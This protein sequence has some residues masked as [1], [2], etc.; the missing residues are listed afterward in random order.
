MH[1]LKCLTCENN[2]TSNIK[3]RKY[4]SDECYH[5]S[6]KKHILY[7][8][9]CIYCNFEFTTKDKEQILCSRKC[10][11]ED[12]KMKSHEM[13]ICLK[14]N[15]EFTVYKKSKHTTCSAECSLSYEENNKRRSDGRF[16]AIQNKFNVNNIMELPEYIQ[17]ISDTKLTRYGNSK[18]NNIEKGKQTLQEKYGVSNAYLLSRSNGTR[19]TKGQ[20]KL[21]DTLKDKYP[22]IL[23][24][25]Q[26]FELNISADIYI[27]SKNLVLEYYGDYWHCNPKFYTSEFYNKSL[28]KQASDIWNKDLDRETKIKA[29]GYNF[30]VIWEDEFNNNFSII[31]DI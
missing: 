19:I 31:N 11:Y 16:L 4:C 5:T 10:M 28:K 9:V 1:V 6:K 26:I 12:R 18:Y 23:L 2:F 24:E 21:Y 15:K 30:K 22:D 3:T 13:R 29:L 20:Q 14:C 8:K 17:K 7:H 27:P 25:Y